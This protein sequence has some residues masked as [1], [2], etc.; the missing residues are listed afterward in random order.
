L[1]DDLD[2]LRTELF[3]WQRGGHHNDAPVTGGFSF[4]SIP[5]Q[6]ISKIREATVVCPLDHPTIF[7][8]KAMV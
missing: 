4:E 1:P 6:I 7:P 3:F 8:K 2:S 5:G